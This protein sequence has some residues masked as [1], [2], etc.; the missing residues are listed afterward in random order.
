MNYRHPW[1]LKKSKSLEPFW[2]YQLNSIANPARLPQN[3][4]KLAKLAV[5]QHQL[6]S[7]LSSW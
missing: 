7:M 4:A 5:L 2:S 6:N 1:Q 3:W